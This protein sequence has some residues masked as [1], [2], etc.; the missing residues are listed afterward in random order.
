MVM[1]G[2]TR[3]PLTTERDGDKDGRDLLN[4]LPDTFGGAAV[5]N[6]GMVV[7]VASDDTD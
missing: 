7:F 5:T 2:G 6:D 4:K 3:L 1:V